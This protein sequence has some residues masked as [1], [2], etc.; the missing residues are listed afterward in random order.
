MAGKATGRTIAL[1]LMT[2][3]VG[4]V[5]IGV[6]ASRK[7]SSRPVKP[8]AIDMGTPPDAGRVVADPG[9]GGSVQD[10]VSLASEGEWTRVDPETGKIAFRMT[11]ARLDPLEDGK[12]DIERPRAW[13]HQGERVFEMSASRAAV[14]WPTRQR[15]PESGSLVGEVTV[16]SRGESAASDAAPDITVRTSALTFE[17]A[18]GELRTTERVDVT[19][20]GVVAA[21]EGMTLRLSA[22]QANPIGLFRVERGG[23]I[24][25]DPAQA[26]ESA[27][28][29][30]PRNDE[31][32]T[33]SAKTA[34]TGAMQHYRATVTGEVSVIA[35]ERSLSGDAVTMWARTRDGRLADNAVADFEQPGAQGTTNKPLAKPASGPDQGVRASF[36]G[37]LEFV[38]LDAAP[39]ELTEDDVLLRVRAANSPDALVALRD[40]ATGGEIKAVSLE[41]AATRRAVYATG[42][43][44]RRLAMDLPKLASVLGEGFSLDLTRGEGAFDGPGVIVAA[45]ASPQD[46]ERSIR[47]N[48]R[49]VF[50]LDTSAGPIGAGREALPR[51]VKFF[52]AVEARDGEARLN[53]AMVN[54]QFET[55]SDTKEPR[56]DLRRLRVS[57]SASAADA[58]GGTFSADDID[59]IFE[60]SA[61]GGD[62]TPVM[63]GARG[64]VRAARR[65]ESLEA[66]SLDTR[67]E[68]DV[69]GDVIVRTVAARDSVRVVIDR[70]GNTG[71][72]EIAAD[73]LDAD[74]Q[75]GVIDLVGTPVSFDRRAGDTT[76]R[77]EGG[78]ARIEADEAARK[79]TVFGAG[80]AEF[81]STG[82]TKSA[83]GAA[84]SFADSARVEWSGSLIYNDATGRAEVLGTPR[85]TLDRGNTER[86]EA[87]GQTII[88]DIT[89]A[90]PDAPAPEQR[91][92]VRAMVEGG[93]APAEIELRRFAP[94]QP[95]KNT[96]RATEAMAFLRGPSIQLSGQSE[97]RVNGPGL[98]LIEDRR[99]AERTDDGAA[100]ASDIRAAARD[101]RG[102]SLLEWDGDLVM[103]RATGAGEARGNVRVR[104]RHATEQRV[105]EITADALSIVVVESAAAGE[106]AMTLSRAEASG[107]V[108][109]I[110]ADATVEGDRLVYDAAA[111]TIAALGSP[112]R[113]A[114][115]YDKKTGRTASAQRVVIELATGNWRAEE[116]GTVTAPR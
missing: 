23:T 38:P 105:A 30:T 39:D 6:V 21:G 49:G 1:L 81:A 115:G 28:A 66:A 95:D 91:E 65:G 70:G 69:R 116:A 33:G 9:A 51:D 107:D 5:A 55:A 77:I 19:A 75:T 46:K 44:Q 61:E 92:L 40:S 22:D 63:A 101:A 89:P 103:N 67:L 26:N 58:R 25:Y 14:V 80:S 56:A 37:V 59:V 24:T 32:T 99:P 20:P 45:P 86:Y 113:P 27:K 12:F 4:A 109:A 108:R 74:T 60:P 78:S 47:W 98:L 48:E 102:T 17:T 50:T 68:R 11:W 54:A 18:L 84:T 10:L 29:A 82:A 110:Y 96:D 114:T 13:M 93:D 111:G 62:P 94:T 34:G 53:G 90:P 8:P 43:G 79:L 52:G 88:V 106:N 72:V 87:S 83:T 16:V 31:P 35:G 76:A 42:A 85:A 97:L 57:G 112:E 104:H 71:I 15:E 36:K 7:P 100:P 73:R 3:V 41:Y 64:N 2:G